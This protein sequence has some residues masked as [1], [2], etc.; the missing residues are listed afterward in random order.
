MTRRRRKSGRSEDWHHRVPDF[1][2]VYCGPPKS[3]TEKESE[4]AVRK[5]K[6]AVSMATD[7]DDTIAELIGPKKNKISLKVY[8]ECKYS[9]FVTFS[10]VMR[11]LSHM[12]ASP[13]QNI[14]MYSLA[15]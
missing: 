2:L 8:Y 3:P 5:R 7:I 4:N 11:A 10:L 1:K 14:V 12:W 15:T 13:P 6:I 9:G